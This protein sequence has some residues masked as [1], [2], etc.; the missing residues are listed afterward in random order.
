MGR[1]ER[2]G[3]RE[4]RHGHDQAGVPAEE[5]AKVEDHAGVAATEQ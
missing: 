3:Y 5:L 4:G 1:L 2:G